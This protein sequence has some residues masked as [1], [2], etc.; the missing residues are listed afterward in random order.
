MNRALAFLY[1]LL[2]YVVFLGTFLYAI[3][4]VAGLVVP[5]T[6]DTG[7]VTSLGETLVID[8]LLLSLFAVQHSVMAR[9]SFKQWWTKFIPAAVE[10]S[11]YVL[12]ASLALI[13]LFWRWRPLP[14]I[15]WQATNPVIAGALLGLSFLGWFIVL[16]ST[17]LINHFELFGLRQVIDH[18]AARSV[19]PPVSRRRSST[20]SCATRS[21]S[22]SS[23]HSGRRQ[24]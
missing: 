1:G 9:A 22:A 17:F 6:I 11:T 10:R 23:S 19:R 21:I 14:I 24:N 13:L 18:L 15:I 12:L 5:K 4:F 2:A 3:G 20:K 8:I 7:E 16:L